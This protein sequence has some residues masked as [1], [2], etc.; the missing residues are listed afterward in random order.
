MSMKWLR[1]KAFN[2]FGSVALDI[3]HDS[4]SP[5]AGVY[6]PTLTLED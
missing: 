5:S 1:I 3:M 2:T 4:N 6:P